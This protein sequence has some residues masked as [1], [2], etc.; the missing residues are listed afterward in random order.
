MAALERVARM[1]AADVAEQPPA[2]AVRGGKG[3]HLD[4]EVRPEPGTET[5]VLGGEL[6]HRDHGYLADV[7]AFLMSGHE[8]VDQAMTDGLGSF[9][10]TA[11]T[12]EALRLCLLLEG[13]HLIEIDVEAPGTG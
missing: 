7:P 11:Q 8:I 13:D 2:G 6:L 9:R 4:L 1:A 3:I 10:L 12:S 5:L